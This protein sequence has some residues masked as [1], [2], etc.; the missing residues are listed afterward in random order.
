VVVVLVALAAAIRISLLLE[1]NGTPLARLEQWR[2]SDMHVYDGWARRIAAGDWLSATVPV[3][4]HSWHHGVARQYFADHPD[5]RATIEREAAEQGR[6]PDELLWSHWMHVPQFYQDPLYPY[7]IAVTYWA[8]GPNPEYVLMW[9]SVLGV[10]SVVLVWVLSR[11]AFGDTVGIVAGLLAALCGPFVLYE[12]LLL[13][14]STILF[15]G[16]LLTWLLHRALTRNGRAA[17]GTLGVALGLACLLKSTFLIVAAGS[18]IVL[19]V[20]D[21]TRWRALVGPAGAL[22]MGF[23]IGIA[24]LVTRNVAVGVAPLSLAA[25]GPLTFLASNDASYLPEVGFGINTP[26]LARFLG[27]TGG[28]WGEAITGSLRGHSMGSYVTLVVA[29]WDR[30]WHW[31]EMPNN[32]NYYYMARQL[33]ILGWLPVTFQIV[34]PL[35][36]IGL[37]IAVRRGRSVWPLYLLGAAMLA[38]MLIFYVLARFRLPFFAAMVPFAAYAVV[39]VATGVAA[40]QRARAAAVVAGAGLLALWTGRPLATNQHLIRMADWILP[41]SVYYQP[42]ITAAV[43]AKDWKR[44]GAW[45]MEFFRRYEPSDREI[46]AATDPTL[47]PELIDMHV[48]CAQLLKLA[49]EANSAASEMKRATDLQRLNPGTVPRD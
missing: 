27:E 49:G 37:V 45:Y 3:P 16:L 32:E 28:G 30:A 43:E 13:R 29:K 38:P 8:V 41:Y 15:T 4:M 22:A 47:R 40:G 12:L 25:S 36:L 31:Y 7:L 5:A 33:P 44:A 14:D 2:E 48:E 26:L 21:R 6:E 46:A 10:L 17:F 34:A 39:E 9:Q 20:R 11:R 18:G 19:I 35:A 24:P 23:A 1:L 42:K